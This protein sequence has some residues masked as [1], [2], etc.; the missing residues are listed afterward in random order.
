MAIMAFPYKWVTL[1]ELKK[2]LKA[3]N[4]MSADAPNMSTMGN[5]IESCFSIHQDDDAQLPWDG[6]NQMMI[7]DMGCRAYHCRHW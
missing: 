3:Q 6:H 7:S 4:A 2:L 5:K 1:F